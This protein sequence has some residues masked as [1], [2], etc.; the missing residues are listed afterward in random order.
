MKTNA[1]KVAT[2]WVSVVLGGLGILGHFVTIAPLINSN[3]VWL[4]MA[5]FV[6]LVLST[7]L[8]DL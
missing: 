3:K 6:L 4:L 1:P 5:G 8:K 7:T 2:W